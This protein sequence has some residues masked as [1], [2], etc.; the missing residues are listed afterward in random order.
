MPQY[1]SW[2]TF[3]Y[4]HVGA[5]WYDPLTGRFLQRDPIG[6]LGGANVYEYGGGN[7]VALAD[8]S[9]LWP[10]GDL[11]TGAVYKGIRRQGYS[12]SE[13][14][15]IV[16]EGTKTELAAAGVMTGAVACVAVAYSGVTTL[17]G[18]LAGGGS[19]SLGTSDPGFVRWGQ[20]VISKTGE[21]FQ[22][23]WRIA[24]GGPR[25]GWPFHAHIHRNNWWAPWRWVEKCK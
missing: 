23:G 4:L 2:N 11:E 7:P 22:T 5:R 19:L 15:Q 16:A 10:R 24:I 9:G 17:G 21:V 1:L 14:S 12:P 20:G 8:P 18:A 3:P 6:I 25:G 13:A